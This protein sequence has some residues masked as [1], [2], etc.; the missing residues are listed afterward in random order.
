M[1]KGTSDQK[2]ADIGKTLYIKL[3][4]LTI[5]DINLMS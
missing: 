3:N 2:Y 1:Q 4:I 5:Y